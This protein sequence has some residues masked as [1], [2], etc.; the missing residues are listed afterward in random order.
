MTLDEVLHS[1][2]GWYDEAVVT[3]PEGKEL[4]CWRDND[5]KYN[6][7]VLKTETIDNDTALRITVDY[8]Y[9]DERGYIVTQKQ[10]HDDYMCK[11]QSERE[12]MSFRQYVSEC[13]GRNGTLERI[14]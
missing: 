5:L 2:H 3:N 14:I 8:L 11:S 7:D 13:C 4:T 6:A 9:W 10:L 1:N 12:E